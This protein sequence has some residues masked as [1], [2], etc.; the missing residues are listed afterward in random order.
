M[1]SLWFLILMP[2]SGSCMLTIIRSICGAPAAL[3]LTA[4]RAGARGTGTTRTRGIP[5]PAE[6][7]LGRGS[8]T[9]SPRSPTPGAVPPARCLPRA[10]PVPAHLAQARHLQAGLP[11][12]AGTADG[13]SGCASRTA[14]HRSSPPGAAASPVPT[15]PRPAPPVRPALP[16]AAAALCCPPGAPRGRAGPCG[17]GRGRPSGP[18]AQRGAAGGVRAGSEEM[19]GVCV[20]VQEVYGCAGC[21]CKRRGIRDMRGVCEREVHGM[22]TVRTCGRYA[23]CARGACGVHARGGRRIQGPFRRR[24]ERSQRAGRGCGVRTELRVR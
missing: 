13:H 19:C 7:S 14:P 15:P 16:L 18:G 12:A 11:A 1:S 22:C 21:V 2:M 10:R 20:S 5:Q 3:S 24:A 23:G 8:Q 17:A 4:E 9:Y 6:L